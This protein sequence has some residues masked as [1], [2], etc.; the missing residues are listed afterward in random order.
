[1]PI[2][3]VF[4]SLSAMRPFH[5]TG[6][7]PIAVGDILL[8][9]RVMGYAMAPH[10]VQAVQALDDVWRTAKAAPKAPVILGEL[11]PAIFDAMVG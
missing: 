7:Q 2:W 8:Q 9:G 11:T 10:H 4:A 5:S 6:P 3:Q 1:M